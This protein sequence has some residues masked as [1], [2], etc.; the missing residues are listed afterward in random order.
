MNVNACL[1]LCRRRRNSSCS[2]QGRSQVDALLATDDFLLCSGRWAVRRRSIRGH[3]GAGCSPLLDDGTLALWLR[4]QWSGGMR[5]AHRCFRD[6]VSH[7]VRRSAA[8]EISPWGAG[9]TANE[10]RRRA[11]RDTVVLP[12]QPIALFQP[13]PEAPPRPSGQRQQHATIYPRILRAH[14]LQRSGFRLYTP[15]DLLIAE[16]SCTLFSP[17]QVT[18]CIR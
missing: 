18:A 9:S 16:S 2:G 15:R 7:V 1:P 13:Q 6:W 4:C 12:W 10:P 11:R 17:C 3:R 14:T 5:G 8:P